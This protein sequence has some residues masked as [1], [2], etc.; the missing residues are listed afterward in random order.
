MAVSEISRRLSFLF[1]IPV[2]SLRVLLVQPYHEIKICD[3]HLS[4]PSG[5]RPWIDTSN[6]NR[7][8]SQMQWYLRDWDTL[9]IQNIDEKL[10][11]LSKYEIQSVKDAK[12]YQTNY[13]YDYYYD[14]S[15]V[16]TG[17]GNSA[18][19]VGPHDIKKP[20]PRVEKGKIYIIFHNNIFNFSNFFINF[21]FY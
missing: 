15:Y 7:P 18:A 4:Q 10:K 14:T 11:K 8:L 21:F 6:E 9:L 20:T 2:N 12:A 3:L 19:T 1:N 5:H 17:T 13:G 16:S